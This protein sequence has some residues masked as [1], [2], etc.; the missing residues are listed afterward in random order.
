MGTVPVALQST[1]AFTDPKTGLLTPYGYQTLVKL[2]QWGGTVP[3]GT[4]THTGALTPHALIKGNGGADISALSSLGTPTTLLHGNAA[5]DPTFGPVSLTADVTGL[6]P[7]ANGGTPLLLRTVT[8]TH[9]QIKAL[10]TTSILL[11]GAPGAGVRLDLVSALIVTSFVAPYGNDDPFGYLVIQMGT[12]DFSNYVANDSTTA[13]VLTDFTDLFVTNA[14][15]SV[16]LGSFTRVTTPTSE[17]WGNAAKVEGSNLNNQAL[18]LSVN[19]NGAGDFTGG[20]VANMLKV[21]LLYRL[22]TV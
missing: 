5:G 15:S 10:P 8:L 9:A 17:G 11:V 22:V 4:V 1:A 19:N 6:L 12:G 3:F 21:F 14:E 20:N 2:I 7:Y 16:S 13:P 18:N